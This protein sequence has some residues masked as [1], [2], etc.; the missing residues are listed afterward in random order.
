MIQTATL[1]LNWLLYHV[2]WVK[3]TIMTLEQHPQ[4]KQSQPKSW[5]GVGVGIQT[6]KLS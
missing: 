2:R 1:N 4:R 5:V 3:N 6:M